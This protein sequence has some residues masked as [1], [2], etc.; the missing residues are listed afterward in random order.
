MCSSDLFRIAF[1]ALASQ[2][3]RT[4]RILLDSLKRR[5]SMRKNKKLL[6]IL[7]FAH[8][9]RDYKESRMVA[10]LL[11]VE[12]LRTEITVQ[13]TCLFPED[14][15]EEVVMGDQVEEPQAPRDTSDRERTLHMFM[16]GLE[17]VKKP[18]QASQRVVYSNIDEEVT[19][20]FQSHEMTDKM[21][22]LTTLHKAMLSVP[23]ASIECERAFSCVSRFN[24]K[25][26]N[27]LSD[28]SLDRLT[29]AKYW[30]KTN[31]L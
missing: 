21:A 12:E 16:S 2:R 7:Y 18:V 17:K 6:S 23:A 31:P 28:D 25:L 20:A 19:A 14:I 15:V 30:M 5:Y 24:T 10:D 11:D 26:R 1:N 9:P 13:Y 22:R 8:S 3:K 29:F 4:A 27:R